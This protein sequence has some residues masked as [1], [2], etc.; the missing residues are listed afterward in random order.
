MATGTDRVRVVTVLGARPQF[1]KAAVV[2]AA[3]AGSGV[4]ETIVHTG[5]HFDARMSDVFFEE[6]GLAAPR[7]HLGIGGL[8]HGAMTGRMLEALEELLVADRPDWVL[9]YGDTNST[10]AAALAASKLHV[11]VAHVEAGMRSFNRRMPEEVNRV[12]TDHVSRLLL[13]TSEAPARLLERE[14]ITEGVHVVGDVM[15]DAQ[16]A[17]ADSARRTGVR[18]RLG[19]TD[20]GYGVVT[21]HRAENTDDR[22]RLRSVATAL[23]EVA[24]HVPLVLPLHPRTRAALDAAGE[25]IDAPG[26]RTIEPIGYLEMQDLEAGAALIL[27]DSGGVQKEALYHAVPCVTMRDETEWTET[28]ELGWNSL[29]G[30]DAEAIVAATRAAL[31]RGPPQQEPPSVYGDGR[32]AQRIAALLRGESFESI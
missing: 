9:V 31:D 17:Y 15:L 24:A 12:L 32:A 30:A 13:V 26:L 2:S 25:R 10:L 7:H 11:P 8:S 6:L 16:H 3:F 28:V 14:G 1:V 22:N 23:R 4:D 20:G 29:V 5:Q 19:L 18:A 27:T 21:W